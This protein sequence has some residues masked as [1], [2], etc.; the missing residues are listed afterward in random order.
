MRH[1]RIEEIVANMEH[2][3]QSNKLH[4]EY[5]QPQGSLVGTGTGTVPSGCLE[6]LVRS[7]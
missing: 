1:N 4:G 5:N 6:L 3:V 7:L 2:K